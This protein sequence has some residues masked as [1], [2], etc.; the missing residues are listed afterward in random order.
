M[1]SNRAREVLELLI[2]NSNHTITIKNIA[3]SFDVSE[4]SIRNDLEIIDDFLKINDLGSICK[5]TKTV[6]SAPN[7]LINQSDNYSDL[8]RKIDV[9]YSYFTLEE[10][11][12]LIFIELLFN[13]HKVKIEDLTEALQVSKSTV[14]S[15]INELKKKVVVEGIEIKNNYKNGYYLVGNENNIRKYGLVLISQNPYLKYKVE[16]S[17]QNG[18]WDNLSSEELN[19]LES[20]IFDLE[21]K[22]NISFSGNAF[23]N[24]LFGLFIFIFRIKQGNFSEIFVEYFEKNQVN[25]REYLILSDYIP[26]IEEKFDIKV[27]NSQ[28][29]Y[30]VSLIQEGNLVKS[31]QYLDENWVDLYLF[32]NNFIDEI[33]RQLG[34]Q[35]IQ[36]SELF[37]A[38]IL[39]LGPAFNRMKNH[40]HLKNEIIDYIKKTYPDLFLLVHDTLDKLDGNRGLAF[41]L[42]E[43]GFI[44]LH[45]AAALEKISA[46]YKMN[47]AIVCNHG[48]GTSTLLRNRIESHLSFNVVT[49][50]KSREVDTHRIE[51]EKIQLIISTIPLETEVP[52]PVEI[53]SPLLSDDE[54][55]RLKKIEVKNSIVNN[56]F[57]NKA[58]IYLMEDEPMLEDL[59]T[60]SV[61]DVNVNVDDWEEA[62]RYGGGLL[63]SEK[64]IEQ[65][66][67]DAMID[68]VKELGPYIVIAPGIAMPH[69]SSK[70]GVNKIGMSLITL[71]E[72]VNFGNSQNDPVKIVL[73]LAAVD[74][75]SHL[76]A[77]SEVVSYLNNEEIVNKLKKSNNPK[78][79]MKLLELES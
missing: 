67:I 55:L 14:M 77:L 22:L 79:I 59:L 76:K 37:Q 26:S 52:I 72:P 19:F 32:T 7:Q 40:T 9:S 53:V 25:N 33:S 70:L 36:D 39:H 54:I 6:I 24:I 2:T 38:L 20:I 49:T 46:N 3:D 50:L 62:V 42:D 44:T 74:P 18:G 4:R 64:I 61:I 5:E 60:E 78:D 1:L 57:S 23:S 47:V 12:E 11:I 16:E 35:L 17:I 75:T 73:T 29:W 27:P 68:S 30:L 28:I 51:D 15:D 8:L 71:K 31:D 45:V 10:R 13:P 58:Q 43:I 21:K 41:N 56:E 69:A 63:K 65:E 34:V 48:I 66:Y